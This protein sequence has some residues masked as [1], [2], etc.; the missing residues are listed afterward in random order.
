[1]KYRLQIMPRNGREN[2]FLRRDIRKI[3]KQ[4]KDELLNEK[5]VERETLRNISRMRKRIKETSVENACSSTGFTMK[6]HS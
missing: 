4:V 6:E 2:T 1:M 3:C 5:C